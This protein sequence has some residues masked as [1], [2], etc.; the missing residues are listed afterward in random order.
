[1]RLGVSGHPG[2]LGMRRIIL[3]RP[4]G[5]G[6]RTGDSLFA[7]CLGAGKA[8]GRH[9]RI[10]VPDLRVFGPRRD[11]EGLKAPCQKGGQRGR[12]H[13]GDHRQH[14]RA[15]HPIQILHLGAGASGAGDAARPAREED[16]L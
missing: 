12:W 2:R 5:L 11:I 1:M 7:A 3:G 14:S 8:F 15:E 16:P 9:R 4:P 13:P 6:T 10:L